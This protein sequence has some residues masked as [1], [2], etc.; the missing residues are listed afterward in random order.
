MRG[1]LFRLLAYIGYALGI[2]LAFLLVGILGYHF[3]VGLPWLDAMLNAAMILSGMGA[4]D[5]ITTVAGKWFASIYAL[6]SG[7]VFAVTTGIIISPILHRVLHHL[8]LK[9]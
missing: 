6:V 9:K 2:V 4:I 7:V 8:H 3:L 1:F 5:P